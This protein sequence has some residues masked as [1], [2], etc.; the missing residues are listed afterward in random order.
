MQ[1]YMVVK[2]G[3]LHKGGT[4]AKGTYKRDPEAVIELTHIEYRIALLYQTF[5]KTHHSTFTLIYDR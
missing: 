4:Q 3:R 5:Y 2:H 1:L